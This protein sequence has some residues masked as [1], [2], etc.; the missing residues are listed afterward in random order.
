MPH[1][2]NASVKDRH[3]T[4]E[5]FRRFLEDHQTLEE[6]NELLLHAVAVCPEC[7]AVGGEV[8]GL[9]ESRAFGLGF[10]SVEVDLAASR[11]AAP[12]LW[13]EIRSLS[14]KR[15]KSLVRTVPRFRTW[16]LCELLCWESVRLAAADAA[17]AVE[18]AELAVLVSDRLKK[19]QPAEELWLYQLRALAW[20]HLGNARRVQGD[21]RKAEQAFGKSVEWWRAS[22][23]AMGNVLDYG[24]RLLDLEASLRRDQRRLPEA[25][26]LLD[27]AL[28][29][30]QGE[31]E[32]RRGHLL[33]NRA[34]ILEEMG[35]LDGALALLREAEDFIDPERDP[36]SAL[37][38][39]HNQLL[40]LTTAGRQ[41]E[42]AR[43]LP[44]VA[45][46]SA[47]LGNDL[48]G[49]RLLWT[50]GRL[51]AGLGKAEE[52]L[53]LLGRVREEFLAR[54][55]GYDAALVTLELASLHAREGRTSEVK[56]LAGE[57]FPVFQSRDVPREAL[58]A[59]A[60][61][62]QAAERETVTADLAERLTAFLRKARYHPGLWFEETLQG[63][64]GGEDARDDQKG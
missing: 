44:E 16:G 50:R 43:L 10:S 5:R 62:H 1:V 39:R 3:L 58:A 41:E 22:E 26:E 59:L 36:R 6:E 9:F 24:S 18:A 11:A 27:R 29:A 52:A 13:E 4:P 64:S 2:P 30:N 34:K 28:L 33:T 37:C 35:D 46:L 32:S 61:F 60:F 21:L 56:A 17:R 19:D 63:G 54:R 12:A 23:P 15:Q 51:A 14:S 20:A 8:L 48:D 40:L 45:R 42:A 47:A 25:R 7:R 49:V 53:H 57:M 31:E 55:I 38:L